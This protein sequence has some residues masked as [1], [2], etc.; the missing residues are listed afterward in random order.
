M[1]AFEILNAIVVLVGVPASVAGLV[2]IGRKLQTLD[3]L[4]E[5]MSRVKHNLNIT[6]HFL[7]RHHENFDLKELQTFSPIQL[8]EEGKGLVRELGF[9]NVFRTHQSEFFGCIDAEH[10]KLKYDVENAAIK[11]LYTLQG[12]DYMEFLKVFFYNNPSRNLENTAPTLGIYLRDQYLAVH[13]EIT[14]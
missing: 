13:P 11:S 2:Y 14:Q 3:S 6:T 5:S 9:D 8:T 12:V 1:T 7:I 10:P 4:E